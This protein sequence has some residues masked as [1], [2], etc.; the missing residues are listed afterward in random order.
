MT[1]H[2]I[3]VLIKKVAQGDME[4]LKILY[5]SMRKPIYFYALR[6]SNSPETAEDVMQ[7][8]FISIMR[9]CG[10]YVSSE[11]G[12]AWIFTIARNRVIDYQKK[13]KTTLPIEDIETAVNPSDP[14]NDF[15]D[16]NSF[17]EIL[18]PLNT[19]ERDVVVLRILSGFSLTQAARELNMP[20]GSAFWTYSN[21]MKKLKKALKG[22]E[23]HVQKNERNDS[24][25]SQPY[26]SE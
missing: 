17:M 16:G 10:G 12:A 23:H 7:D 15:I 26:G 14:I 22:E 21:A 24:I 11:K 20:K 2:E 13:Q 25:T 6:L 19:K 1:N 5:E 8:T 18:A 4:A 3:D 9:S